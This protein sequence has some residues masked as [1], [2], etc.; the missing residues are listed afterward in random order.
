MIVYLS[1]PITG[2]ENFLDSFFG[3][4]FQL[5]EKGDVVLNPAALPMGLSQEAYMHIGI[6]M[7]READ[8]VCKLPGW[9][10]SI[11]AK[12]EVALADKCGKPVYTLDELLRKKGEQP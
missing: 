8:C 11:G 10:D 3:A 2:K 9:E 1:G 6:A 4:E 7:L 5:M 12:V